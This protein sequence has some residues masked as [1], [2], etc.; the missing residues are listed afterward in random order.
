VVAV[1]FAT[2]KTATTRLRQCLYHN[3]Q[4]QRRPTEQP[5]QPIIYMSTTVPDM[6]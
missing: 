5:D 3:R 4:R 2:T 6:S 1:V